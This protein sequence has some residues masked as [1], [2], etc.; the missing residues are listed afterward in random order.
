MPHRRKGKLKRYGARV[1]SGFA[2]SGSPI[3]GSSR[4]QQDEQLLGIPSIPVTQPLTTESQRRP[5]QTTREPESETGSQTDLQPST[6][7]HKRPGAIE[8]PADRTTSGD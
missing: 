5:S 1:Q 3:A 8:T 2:G 4:P 6:R 7:P